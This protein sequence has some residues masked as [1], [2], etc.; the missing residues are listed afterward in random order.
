[1][2]LSANDKWYTQAV[3]VVF[4]VCGALQSAGGIG[5]HM[6]TLS[7]SQTIQAI[8]WSKIG[9]AVSLLLLMAIKLSIGSQLHRLGLT[10]RWRIVLWTT[11]G[12]YS[13]I[14]IFTM[15]TYI[16]RCTPVRSLWVPMPDSEVK[17]VFALE[18][19][20]NVSF[21]QIGTIFTSPFS[22]LNQRD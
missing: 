21:V 4:F 9:T 3:N 7:K 14:T 22:S 11:L 12:V 20:R 1:M 10:R 5:K 8:K 15:A 2:N 18:S 19:W 16:G 17:C 13:I 6:A